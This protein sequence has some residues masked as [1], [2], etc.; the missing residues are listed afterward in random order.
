MHPRNKAVPV[1]AF[2]YW[3][4]LNL[5]KILDKFKRI[6]F[7]IN[8]TTSNDKYF[9]LRFSLL[10]NQCRTQIKNLV[11]L[12]LL[13]YLLLSTTV[14]L[15]FAHRLLFRTEHCNMPSSEHFGILLSP[16]AVS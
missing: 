7:E 16:A 15:G 11:K 1:H 2:A 12:Y 3:H 4:N 10:L 14:Y 9:H 5:C 6:F 8:R 13:S